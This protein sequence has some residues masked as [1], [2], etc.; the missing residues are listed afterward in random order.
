M[1]AQ[2]LNWWGIH[3]IA[4]RNKQTNKSNL[5]INLPFLS[6]L[7]TLPLI[8]KPLYYEVMPLS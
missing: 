6:F 3:F 7:D 2:S 1:L 8:N 5:Y 4:L